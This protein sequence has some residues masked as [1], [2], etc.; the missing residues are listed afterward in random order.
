MSSSNFFRPID[1]YLSPLSF[2]EDIGS[3]SLVAYLSTIDKDVGDT[4]SYAFVSGE[5]D[6]DNE[7]FNIEGNQLK[8][9]FSPD[10]E[11]KSNYSIRIETTDSSGLTFE[12][13]FTLNVNILIMH[14]KKK[15]I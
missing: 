2:D 14:Q 5:G 4:H 6:E 11:I 7:L 12:K 15:K 1:I 10:Y 9:N 3:S 8:I 13:S